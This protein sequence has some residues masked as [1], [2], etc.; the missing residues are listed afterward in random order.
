MRSAQNCKLSRCL[1]LIF[2]LCDS[3]RKLQALIDLLL[4]GS[5]EEVFQQYE[6]IG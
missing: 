6:K 5:N 1:L 4:Q 3:A 2:R